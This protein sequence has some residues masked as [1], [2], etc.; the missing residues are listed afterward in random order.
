[1]TGCQDWVQ[2]QGL[3]A[4]RGACVAEIGILSLERRHSV[5]CRSSDSRLARQD[6]FEA[7][8][9]SILSDDLTAGE[10]V[11][12]TVLQTGVRSAVRPT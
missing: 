8:T 5:A 6:R 10:E 1:M 11:G 3:H 4:P 9:D 12:G 7:K 2:E